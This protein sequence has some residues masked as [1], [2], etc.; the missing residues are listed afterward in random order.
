MRQVMHVV[1]DENERLLHRA[2]HVRD[3]AEDFTSRV[4]APRQSQ[5]CRVVEWSLTIH[6]Y[7]HASDEQHHIGIAGVTPQP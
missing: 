5:R 4:Q 7:G 6:R 1:Q 3:H 2:E